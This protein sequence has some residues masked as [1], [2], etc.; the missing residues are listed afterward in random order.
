[1]SCVVSRTPA[2][3]PLVTEPGAIGSNEM[4]ADAM[5]RLRDWPP[6]LRESWSG[7]GA[8]LTKVPLVWKAP[9][10]FRTASLTG[11][12]PAGQPPVDVHGGV[13]LMRPGSGTTGQFTAVVHGEGGAPPSSEY[14]APASSTPV[15]PVAEVVLPA[16]S[17]KPTT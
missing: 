8:P 11:S 6:M 7:L 12:V 5:F 13:A 17:S 1:M 3:G 14:L 10:N 4:T 16:E 2:I 9:L 15:R